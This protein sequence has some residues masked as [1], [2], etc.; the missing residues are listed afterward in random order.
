[1]PPLSKRE[2]QIK[3]LAKDKR[4]KNQNFT[5]PLENSDILEWEN[6]K[7]VIWGD[8]DLD[9][10][11]ETFVKESNQSDNQESEHE[12]HC[13]Y[14][15]LIKSVEKELKQSNLDGGYKLRLTA[16]LQYLRLVNHKEPKIKASL[17][18]ARQLNKGPYFARC[19]RIVT[20]LRENKFEFYVANF[21][22][23]V[24]NIVFPSLGIEQETTK[25]T[26]TVRKWLKKME[27]EFKRFT[28]GVYVDGHERP[29]VIEYSYEKL[30]PKFDNNDLEIQIN[31]DLQENEH[32]HILVT[33]DETTFHSNDGRRSG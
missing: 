9:E 17:C 11:A 33:H 29:N 19:L 12:D 16:L 6:E 1:M 2:K 4:K 7:E 31:P 8:D 10:K 21:I 27:F 25:S 13:E 24:K 23:Y 30:M 14:G 3:S 32:L 18:I 20:Y 22:D 15:Q 5:V 28:K 26:K